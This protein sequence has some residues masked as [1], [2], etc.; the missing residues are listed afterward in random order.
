MIY[1]IGVD[2]LI[3]YKGPV[4]EAIRL[5]F[6]SYIIESCRMRGIQFIAE[7]FSNEALEKV[8]NS[9]KETAH[10]AAEILKIGHRYCDPEEKELSEMG[11]PYYFDVMQEVKNRHSISG[12]FILDDALREKVKN[13]TDEIVRTYWSLRE[14]YWYK[15]IR[16]IIDLPILFICGHE[17]VFRFRSLLDTKGHPCTIINAF[18]KKDL[19]NNYGNVNLS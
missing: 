2:H 16:D 5:E 9:T 8:Y 3:Q 6:R 11:I 10:E 18:W 15:Q 13:E 19:F 4:P 1:L 14:E 7:E 12:R 17:H